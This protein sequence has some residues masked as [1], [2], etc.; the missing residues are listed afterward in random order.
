MAAQVTTQ[1][2]RIY[3]RRFSCIPP[4]YVRQYYLTHK[5]VPLNGHIRK[6]VDTCQGHRAAARAQCLAAVCSR[7]AHLATS[8]VIHPD[9]TAAARR[10]GTTELS[11]LV[12]STTYNPA[13]PFGGGWATKKSMVK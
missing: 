6:L 2:T 1:E 9:A 12:Y 4:E 3:D 10:A 5:G 13:H 8:G 11:S 7:M